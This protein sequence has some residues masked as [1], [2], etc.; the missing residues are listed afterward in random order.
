MS[1]AGEKR[2]RLLFTS[3]TSYLRLTLI[4]RR[5]HGQVLNKTDGRFNSAPVILNLEV[6]DWSARESEI[7]QF[8]V[9]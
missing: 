4:K 1:I 3:F 7:P 5:L 9:K 8:V 6:T 2:R